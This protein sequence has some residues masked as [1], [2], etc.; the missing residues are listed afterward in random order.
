M[1]GFSEAALETDAGYAE[2]SYDTYLKHV[3]YDDLLKYG[4]TPCTG[5][6][7]ADTRKHLQQRQQ[8]LG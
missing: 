4:A 6:I 5:T 1:S 8:Q 3:S 2:G 7:D